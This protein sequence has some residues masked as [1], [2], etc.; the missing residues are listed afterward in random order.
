MQI[1][2]NINDEALTA[3]IEQGVKGLSDEQLAEI[4]KEAIMAYMMDPNN[5]KKIVFK[6][7]VFSRET[8]VRPE[9]LQML[10]NSF[11]QSEIEAYRQKMFD[12]ID[13]HGENLLANTLAQVF[14]SML[15]TNEF[16]NELAAQMWRMSKGD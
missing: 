8:E 16:K 1:T 9:F 15:L 5:I 3:A 12:V 10:T 2:V 7:D 11:S 6:T 4:T 14:S 13:K